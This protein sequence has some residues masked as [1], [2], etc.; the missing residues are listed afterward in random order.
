MVVF[1]AVFVVVDHVVVVIVVDDPKIKSNLLSL[2]K[3]GSATAEIMVILSM[4]TPSYVIL[5]RL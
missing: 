5:C 2:L 1:Y 3:I 4:S